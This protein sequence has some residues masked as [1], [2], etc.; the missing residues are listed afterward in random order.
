MSDA[1]GTLILG[2]GGFLGPHLVRA[3]LAAGTAP[4]LGVRRAADPIPG[5]GPR[6]GLT[7]RATDARRPE[8]VVRLLDRERPR[9]VLLA[10]ALS[11]VADCEHDPGQAETL[12]TE[13]PER[14]ARWC[15]AEGVRL[16]FVSTDLVF[17]GEP[18]RGERYTEEDPP[19]PLHAYGHTKAE[20]ER[21]VR[22]SAPEALVV[23]LPLLYGDSAG[24]GLGASDSVL[25][26]VARGERP[27]LFRDEWRTPLDVADAAR[28]TVEAASSPL[29]GLLHVAGPRRLSRLELGLET[30]R[31]RKRGSGSE[32]TVDSATR[33]E[34]GLAEI[35]AADVSLDSSRALRVLRT[36]LPP[37]EEALRRDAT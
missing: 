1:G 26:A 3:A 18:P 35:R 27:R 5:L 17:G 31:A 32:D 8:A 6:E 34:A 20:G 10:A 15:A 37:P 9:V 16:V 11:R 33:A 24:Q 22:R 29:Q 36:P 12:N 28:A 2:A 4:V 14:V 13:L 21:R 23:R 7:L 25:A 19:R 30:L